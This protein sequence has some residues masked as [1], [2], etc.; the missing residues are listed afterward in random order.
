MKINDLEKKIMK[1]Y[2]KA[3]KGSIRSEYEEGWK[4]ALLYVLELIS[5]G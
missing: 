4:G 2:R 1:E 3:K 5:E